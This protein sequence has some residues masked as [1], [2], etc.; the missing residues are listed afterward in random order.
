MKGLIAQLEHLGDAQTP[1]AVAQ[2]DRINEQFTI[3]FDEQAAAKAELETLTADQPAAEDPALI[4]NCPT[5]PACSPARP[6][7]YGR[8][9]T[10]RSRSTPSTAPR[11]TR[12]PSPPPSPTRPPT[13]STP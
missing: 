9:S 6:P 11:S 10:P 8:A 13:S 5:R 1:A 12:P 2:R 3:R 4:E 7:G